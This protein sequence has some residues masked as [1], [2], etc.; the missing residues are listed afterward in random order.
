MRPIR[1]L[2][3]VFLSASATALTAFIL[4]CLVDPLWYFSGNVLTGINYPFNERLAKLIRFSKS[5]DSYNCIIFGSSRVT[6][7]NEHDI[8]KYSCFNFAFSSGQIAEFVELGRY[9]KFFGFTPDLM[10]VGVDAFNFYRPQDI[11]RLPDFVVDR[12]PPPAIIWTYLS[13]DAIDFAIR[14]LRKDAPMRRFYLRDLTGAIRP[15]LPHAQRPNCLAIE[16]KVGPFRQTEANLYSKLKKIWPDARFVGYVPPLSTWDIAA[17]DADGTLDSY[18]SAIYSTA[19]IFDL[20]IDFSVPSEIT[21]DPRNTVD[22]DHFYRPTNK[23]IA[24]RLSGVNNGFGLEV[25]AMGLSEYRKQ[26]FEAFE[27]FVRPQRL[28]IGSSEECYISTNAR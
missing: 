11:S 18:L 26:F 7:L 6:V 22:G 3:A 28:S 8:A 10:I 9:L 27:R 13:I 19:R 16:P 20:L 24:E 14:T 21:A 23:A 12:K 1:Y 4:V 25:S 2:L 5:Q 17:I 15:D